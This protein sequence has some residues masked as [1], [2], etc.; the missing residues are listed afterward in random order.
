MAKAPVMR[1]KSMFGAV[2]GSADCYTHS[3]FNANQVKPEDAQPM[4]C[5][6]SGELNQSSAMVVQ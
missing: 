5:H 4:L 6:G 1:K 2:K 3:G